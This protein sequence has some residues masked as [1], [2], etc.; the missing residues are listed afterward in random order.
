MESATPSQNRFRLHEGDVI[1]VDQ[2]ADEVYEQYT[3]VYGPI[4]TL[5]RR[6]HESAVHQVKGQDY[7]TV[8]CINGGIAFAVCDGVGQSFCGD[9]A[10]KFLGDTLM[11]STDLLLSSMRSDDPPTALTNFLNRLVA[12]AAQ[13]TDEFVLP[14]ST[15][16]LLKLALEEMRT[17]GSET[18]FVYGQLVPP[19]EIVDS[20]GNAGHQLYLCWLG[21]TEVQVITDHHPIH[22]DATWTVQERWSTRQGVRGADHVHFRQIPLEQVQRILVYSD[23]L[24]S[25]A[26]QLHQLVQEPDTL[27]VQIAEISQSPDSD[28]ISLLDIVVEPYKPLPASVPTE[29]IVIPKPVEP[30]QTS[31]VQTSAQTAEHQPTQNLVLHYLSMTLLVVLAVICGITFWVVHWLLLD[32]LLLDGTLLELLLANE[33]ETIARYYVKI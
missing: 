16:P 3:S 31:S 29:E 14:T 15:P 28:D 22:L 5:Y 10:A 7:L 26:N 23:G 12:E 13:R 11:D 30:V 2:A 18:M 25:I 24:D 4:R 17:Y 8:G 9:L 27:R 1:R 21:D 19:L 32:W 33:I 6:S 20:I